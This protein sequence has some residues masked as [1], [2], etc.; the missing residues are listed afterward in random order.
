[1]SLDPQHS[2]LAGIE[3]RGWI[4]RIELSI[5]GLIL[6]SFV[7]LFHAKII[8]VFPHGR[9]KNWITEGNNIFLPRTFRHPGWFENS[10]LLIL[11]ML[12]LL[13]PPKFKTQTTTIFYSNLFICTIYYWYPFD[14]T[15]SPFQEEHPDF[16][17]LQS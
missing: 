15:N 10:Y 11:Y 7:S 13:C 14:K 1:M 5:E 6:T 3:N 4:V 2:K 8:L 16:L 17:Q 9:R 12:L